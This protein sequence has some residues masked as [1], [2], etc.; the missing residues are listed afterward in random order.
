MDSEQVGLRQSSNEIEITLGL[1]MR[2]IKT[3][4]AC[5]G[6]AIGLGAV[7]LAV[8]CPTL[9]FTARLLVLSGERPL[10]EVQTRESDTFLPTQAEIIRSPVV[11]Q[12]SLTSLSALADESSTQDVLARLE[13]QPLLGTNV[14]TLRLQDTSQET[15]LKLLNAIIMNYKTYLRDI[16]QTMNRETITL[17]LDREKELRDEMLT[18]QEEYDATH[19][20]GPLVGPDALL[21]QPRARLE[22]VQQLLAASQSRRVYLESYLRQLETLERSLIA[23]DDPGATVATS[24]SDAPTSQNAPISNRPTPT[25]LN[26]S[27]WAASLEILTRMDTEGLVRSYDPSVHQALLEARSQEAEVTQRFGPRHPEVRAI[28]SRIRSLEER[29]QSAVRLA[30]AILTS[31]LASVRSQE[32]ELELSYASEFAR[33]K[34]L[35]AAVIREQQQL[36]RLQSVQAIHDTVLTQINR[37]QL[38]DEAISGGRSSVSVRLLDGPQ[39]IPSGTWPQPVPVLGLCCILGLAVGF[40]VVVIG[41]RTELQALARRVPN[42][43]KTADI[44]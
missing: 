9:E 42:E 22:T 32:G 24:I 44:G 34:Q 41:N 29:L 2:N 1:L 20:A 28:Q 35:D 26:E 4:V 31:E 5:T 3:L 36:D 23:V 19:N 25:M 21:A 10:D 30:P 13:V 12:Q 40:L 43:L 38:A 17:L 18:L 37:F 6:I 8:A 27:P 33:C 14:M 16:E 7:Y 39:L 11:I 15:G